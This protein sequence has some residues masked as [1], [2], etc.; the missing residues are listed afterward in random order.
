[1]RDL[2]LKHTVAAG[3][4]WTGQHALYGG[5]STPAIYLSPLVR[6]ATAALPFPLSLFFSR[7]PRP[8]GSTVVVVVLPCPVNLD[9]GSKRR[10]GRARETEEGCEREKRS[11]GRARRRLKYHE[12]IIRY[13]PR[14]LSVSPPSL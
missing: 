13:P 4:S 3:A 1:M 2:L 7:L 5:T 11:G 10:S 9:P 14:R 12:D 8:C 6:S